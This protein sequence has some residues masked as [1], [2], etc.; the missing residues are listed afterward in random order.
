LIPIIL[1]P[2]DN[3]ILSKFIMGAEMSNKL[4]E[5]NK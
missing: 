1:Q 3:K 5:N 4:E 2:V